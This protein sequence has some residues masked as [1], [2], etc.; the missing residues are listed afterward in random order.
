MSSG[1]TNKQATYQHNNTVGT[2]QFYF[3]ESTEVTT[4]MTPYTD[5]GYSIPIPWNEVFTSGWQDSKPV[6][7]DGKPT[8]GTENQ[9][10]SSSKPEFFAPDNVVRSNVMPQINVNDP[11]YQFSRAEHTYKIW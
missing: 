2:K 7:A 1:V 3:N 11:Q 8:W 5:L 6:H 4:G 9:M 10:T